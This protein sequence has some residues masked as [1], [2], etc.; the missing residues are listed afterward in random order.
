MTANERLCALGLMDEYD[1][2]IRSRDRA[3]LRSILERVRVDAAS[4][5]SNPGFPS[6]RRLTSRFLE[7]RERS[8][9]WIHGTSSRSR[10]FVA[11]FRFSRRGL[12][13]GFRGR[14]R[15]GGQAK[16]ALG[17][18]RGCSRSSRRNGPSGLLLAEGS[19]FLRDTCPGA[20]APDFLAS[21]LL[22][23]VRAKWRPMWAVL[24]AICCALIAGFMCGFLFRLS[25]WA[26]PA[27]TATTDVVL[28]LFLLFLSRRR[29]PVG[30][31]A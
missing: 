2:A 25:I 19:G 4:I 11:D 28:I 30:H 1:H 15:L 13:G 5:R 23:E 18:A 20:D 29:K 27:F 16:P 6:W 14:N 31:D 12:C 26:P 17:R 10:L 7:R 21:G 22:L 9:S 24:A 8:A 3:R